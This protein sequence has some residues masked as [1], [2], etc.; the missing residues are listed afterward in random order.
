MFND[1]QMN[2]WLYYQGG[3][4]LLN[5][6]YATQNLYGLPCGNT[7]AQMGGWYR[8]EINTIDDLKG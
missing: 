3:Q 2:A 7:G 5:E 1:R 6:F 8:K 4:D